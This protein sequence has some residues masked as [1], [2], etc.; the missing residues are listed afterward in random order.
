MGQRRPTQESTRRGNPICISAVLGRFLETWAAVLLFRMPSRHKVVDIKCYT[1]RMGQ[2]GLLSTK[3]PRK[4]QEAIEAEQ[5]TLGC[6]NRV[7]CMDK[8]LTSYFGGKGNTTTTGRKLDQRGSMEDGATSVSTPD[9]PGSDPPGV[10]RQDS[11]GSTGAATEKPKTLYGGKIY[12]SVPEPQISVIEDTRRLEEVSRERDGYRVK[13][14][15]TAQ[16]LAAWQSMEKHAPVPQILEHLG[17][18]PNC[19]PQLESFLDRYVKTL[20]PDKVKELARQQK[21]WPPPS[22]EIVTRRR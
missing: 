1:E 20:P 10:N 12:I 22:F 19:R 13:A 5:E 21:W 4:W 14:E 11:S 17:N 15:A 3:V 18:C 9:T 7:E 2:R 8:M 16:E 6:V